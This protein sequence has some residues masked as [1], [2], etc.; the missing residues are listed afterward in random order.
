MNTQIN[1]DETLVNKAAA[2]AYNVSQEDIVI[3]LREFIDRHKPKTEQRNA[4][5]TKNNSGRQ[6]NWS[7]GFIRFMERTA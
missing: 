2:L 3:A 1:V 6:N 5:F 4:M 7:N